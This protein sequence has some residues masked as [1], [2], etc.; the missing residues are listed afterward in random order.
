VS[1]HD[2]VITLLKELDGPADPQP[3]FADA[4]SPRS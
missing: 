4:L 2:A 3:E 1:E